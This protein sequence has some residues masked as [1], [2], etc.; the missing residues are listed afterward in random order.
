MNPVQIWM[1]Y[2]ASIGTSDAIQQSRLDPHPMD[3]SEIPISLQ[4]VN[5]VIQ[6]DLPHQ[7]GFNLTSSFFDPTT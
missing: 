1:Q 3:T 7:P 4:V 5:G 6:T 2:S